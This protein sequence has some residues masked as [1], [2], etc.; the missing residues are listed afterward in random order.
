MGTAH[1]SINVAT[2]LESNITISSK[3]EER[4]LHHPVIAL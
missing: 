3:V 1:Y 2:I 4:V